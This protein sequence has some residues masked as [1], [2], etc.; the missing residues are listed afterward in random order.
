MLTPLALASMIRQRS[1]SRPYG[2]Y[3]SGATFIELGV[4]AAL[5][6][7]RASS[8]VRLHRESALYRRMSR[9]GRGL[10]LIEVAAGLVERKRA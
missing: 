1:G 10:T 2:R 8:K 9:P 5:A 7:S 3:I 4:Y 6:S